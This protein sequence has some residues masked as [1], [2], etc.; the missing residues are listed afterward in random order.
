MAKR[1]GV[2]AVYNRSMSQVTTRYGYR[3]R[4]SYPLGE[5]HIGPALNQ[6]LRDDVLVQVTGQTK[7]RTSVLYTPY[8]ENQLPIRV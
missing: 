2:L 5:V 8:Q 6:K 3:G 1:R 7:R 4:E